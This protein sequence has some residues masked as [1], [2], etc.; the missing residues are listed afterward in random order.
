M[1]FTRPPHFPSCSRLHRVVLRTLKPHFFPRI[2]P[3]YPRYPRIRTGHWTNIGICPPKALSSL[4]SIH[5]WALLTMNTIRHFSVYPKRRYFSL[6][7]AADT[8]AGMGSGASPEVIAPPVVIF[9]K[10]T[11]RC[12]GCL[13]KWKVTACS[14]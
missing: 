7:I 13:L 2:V 1:D 3:R 9:S 6:G 8:A 10:V 5:I 11:G 12:A 14:K 4:S